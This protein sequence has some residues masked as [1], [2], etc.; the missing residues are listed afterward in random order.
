MV[1]FC[2]CDRTSLLLTS[3]LEAEH[4]PFLWHVS[5]RQKDVESK[6]SGESKT[7]TAP[8]V[9]WHISL[10]LHS[11]HRADA[12]RMLKSALVS[13]YGCFEVLCTDGT[14]AA[15]VTWEL[16][17]TAYRCWT[18]RAQNRSTLS[19]ATLHC[20]TGPCEKKKTSIQ[21]SCIII[22]DVYGIDK[23]HISNCRLMESVHWDLHCL[24]SLFTPMFL[25]KA[26]EVGPPRISTVSG[27]FSL[28]CFSVRGMK[29]LHW[30]CDGHCSACLVVSQKT[31]SSSHRL[32]V[33]NTSESHR[34]CVFN[35]SESHRWCVFN[36]SESHSQC[37]FQHIRAPQTML[38]SLQ[39]LPFST[40]PSPTD[41]AVFPTDDDIFNTSEPHRWCCLRAVW[42][43]R[44]IACMSQ[45]WT[46]SLRPCGH[47][48][49]STS[50][51]KDHL[52]II[53]LGDWYM[54]M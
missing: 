21:G 20:I 54:T 28:Q 52:N 38:S 22:T 4:K 31:M 40:H 13:I 47:Q 30:I 42:W 32:C 18:E 46:T 33:F 26:D 49:E 37:C 45:H 53:T 9:D 12:F 14:G 11:A 27:L 35:T 29:L 51:A 36:T 15:V 7:S 44:S 39:T 48:A 24:W 8:Y 23:C 2:H 25:N 5:K 17:S 41:N 34:W 16:H 6:M 19:L 3:L 50:C 10:C 43:L 1:I